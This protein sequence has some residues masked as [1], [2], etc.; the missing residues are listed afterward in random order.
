MGSDVLSNDDIDR[1]VEDGYLALR[2][3]VSPEVATE[4]SHS[5]A[6]F[7]SIDAAEC[8]TLGRASI[9]ELPV[10]ERAVSPAVR[11]AFD[12][13]A[14]DGRWQVAR[15]WGF[16][17]RLPGTVT[18]AWHI[19]GDWFTHHLTS[20]DQMLTPIFLWRDVGSFDSPTLLAPG[21][22]RAVA[23]LIARFEPDGISGPDIV[24]VVHAE[25]RLDA[26]IE[27]TGAAG[28]VFVCHPFLAHSINPAGP[29][30]PRLISNVAVHGSNPLALT[31]SLSDLTPVEAAIAPALRS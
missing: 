17:I 23:K 31:G 14:G 5:A 20:A 11:A 29:S 26:V 10:L 13:L 22:H 12:Q 1:F 28:D 6:S 21:S 30:T 15:E 25:L 8:W 2:G 18:P 19:D 9:T 7:V 16:P 3:A 4:I 27:A 24:S